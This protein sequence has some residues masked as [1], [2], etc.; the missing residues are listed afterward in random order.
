MSII[1]KATTFLDSVSGSAMTRMALNHMFRSYG[2]I[3]YIR[4]NKINQQVDLSLMLHG[5]DKSIEVRVDKYTV[6]KNPDATSVIIDQLKSDKLWLHRLLNDL[7]VG[8]SL[9]LPSGEYSNIIEEL[10]LDTQI[11]TELG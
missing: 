9:D 1:G 10:L 8:T 5:E 4:I 11:A 6:I 3:T 7:V 2:K